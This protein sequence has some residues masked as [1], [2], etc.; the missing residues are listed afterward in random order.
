MTRL[1]TDFANRLRWDRRRRGFYEV[2]YLKWN[3]RESQ[4]AGWIRY[5]LTSPKPGIGDPFCEL[6][7]IFF[8]AREPRHHVAVKNRFPIA[9]LQ[10]TAEPFLL[11]L[12]DAELSSRHCRG[13]INDSPEGAAF[14]WDLTFASPD[15]PVPLLPHRALYDLTAF[16]K[17]KVLVAHENA[18]LNGRVQVGSRLIELRDAPGQQT[19]LWGVKHAQ[20]WAWG[21]C[22][23]FTEEP[24]AVWEGLDAQIR[25]GPFDPHFTLFYLKAFGREHWFNS[26]AHLVR[27]RSAWGPESWE[28]SAENQEVS[29]SGVIVNR[30]A[31]IVTVTYMDPD[32]AL[33]Y[34]HNSKIA[35]LRLTVTP[36][37]GGETKTLTATRLCAAEF[38]DRVIHPGRKVYL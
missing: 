12:D 1:E 3:D 2:Y 34:C 15:P 5:T 10:N 23:A 8:D 11:R 31:D 32:G 13:R 19:H 24:D 35:D 22:N 21:H 18:R 29:L 20:R 28:F 6:W 25:L 38:V 7:A 9:F 37:R 4:T 16:P 26:F 17:T 27:N 14:A 30:P 33:L 36:R